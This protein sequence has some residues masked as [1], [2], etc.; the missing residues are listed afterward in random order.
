MSRFVVLG[1]L[2]LACMTSL[3]C[4]VNPYC[5]NCEV[6]DG[7]SDGGPPGDGSD[8]GG[9]DADASNCIPDNP[10]D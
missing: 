4:K 7:G 1:A 6:G 8:G 2:A 10:P 3:S 9:N 5:L